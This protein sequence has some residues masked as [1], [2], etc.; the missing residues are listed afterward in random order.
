MLEQTGPGNGDRSIAEALENLVHKRPVLEPIL[1]TFGEILREKA[2]L[3]ERLTHEDKQNRLGLDSSRLTKAIPLLAGI[4]LEA[5]QQELSLSFTAILPV[6]KRTFGHLEGD[7]SRL[8]ALHHEY[9]LD[10]C[11][12]SRAWLDGNSTLLGDAAQSLRVPEGVLGMVISMVLAPVLEV[13]ALPFREQVQQAGWLRGYCPICGSMPSIS[14]LAR[15][16]DPASESLVGGG[17]QRYLHCSVCG[18]EWRTK[19]NMCPACENEDKAQI[20]YQIEENHSER[21][22]VCSKCGAYLPCIDL[23]E[24]ESKPSLDIEAVG[25]V[26]LDV[27]ARQNGY[28]PLAWTPWNQVD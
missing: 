27:W 9:N 24:R 14:F 25:M 13:V 3:V 15:L 12:L 6:F 17:G 1:R 4:S 28:H 21:V 22:D 20:Y 26:H 11:T 18:C 2:R 8:E 19:R 7:L 10:L 16:R 23:R 5:L